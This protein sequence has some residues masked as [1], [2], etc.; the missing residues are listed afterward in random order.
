MV[1]PN[2]EIHE[3]KRKIEE[4]KLNQLKIELEEAEEDLKRVEKIFYE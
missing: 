3:E 1:W 2:W 4:S